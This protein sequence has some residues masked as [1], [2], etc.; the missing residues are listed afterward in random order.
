MY[1][2]KNLKTITKKKLIKL[3]NMYEDTV[4]KYDKGIKFLGKLV[5][6]ELRFSLW[7]IG[8]F[9]FLSFTYYIEHLFKSEWIWSG[10]WLITMIAYIYFF[11]DK[12]SFYNKLKGGL[13]WKT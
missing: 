3:L 5:L 7:F 9:L 8:L 10:V 11:Y 12:F 4:D 2:E 6:N 1:I 13:Q